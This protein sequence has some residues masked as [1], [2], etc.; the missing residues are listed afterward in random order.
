MTAEPFDSS[1]IVGTLRHDFL[2]PAG[3]AA[4]SLGQAITDEDC[5]QVVEH[6]GRT[7]WRLRERLGPAV[8]VTVASAD[9]TP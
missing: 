8:L 3:Q 6:P 4:P 5:G 9:S 7:P 2:L 1:G